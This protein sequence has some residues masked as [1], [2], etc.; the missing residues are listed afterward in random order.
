M[1]LAFATENNIPF[2]V[3]PKVLDLVREL[4]KD[5]ATLS[6]LKLADRTTASYKVRFG[7]AKTFHDDVIAVAKVSFFSLNVDEAFAENNKKI[8]AILVSFYHTEQKKVVVHHLASL[9][10]D[11]VTSETVYNA[12]VETV[13]RYGL[14]WGKLVSIL[15]DSCSVMRGARSGVEQRIRA[16]KAPHLLDIDGDIIHHIQNCSKVLCKLFAS[17]AEYLFTDLYTEFHYSPDKRCTLE[18]I[19]TSL[20]VR[21]TSPERFIPHRYFKNRTCRIS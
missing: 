9:E 13:E 19:C 21:Y 17:V 3:V 7:V 2:S 5:P 12:I 16:N 15:M 8:L 6:E 11:R 18:S 10:L 14:S 4:S 20:G 1:I